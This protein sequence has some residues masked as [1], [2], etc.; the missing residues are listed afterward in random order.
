[1][2]RK[3]R[4]GYRT[5]KMKDEALKLVYQYECSKL[6]VELDTLKLVF[7]FLYNVITDEEAHYH[8]TQA[9]NRIFELNNLN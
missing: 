4:R 8:I 5:D 7:N 2:N 9:R 6:D 3:I 1:M